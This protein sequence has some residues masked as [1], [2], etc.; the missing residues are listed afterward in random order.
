MTTKAAQEPGWDA[1]GSPVEETAE[2][3]RQWIIAS[4]WQPHVAAPVPYITFDS[5]EALTL[6]YDCGTGL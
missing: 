5:V 3:E 1:N 2:Q 6:P 4:R